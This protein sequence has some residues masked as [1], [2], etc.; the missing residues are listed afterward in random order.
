M[1]AQ[2]LDQ[3]IA[4]VQDSARNMAKHWQQETLVQIVEAQVLREQLLTLTPEQLEFRWSHLS[5]IYYSR[6]DEAFL[7]MAYRQLFG[8]PVDDDGLTTYLGM[9]TQGVPR[10]HIV[11]ILQQSPEAQRS[12]LVL[13]GTH[14]AHFIFKV[15][16]IIAR[17]PLLGKK[18]AKRLDLLI[19]AHERAEV[20]RHLPIQGYL[21]ILS[22][23]QGRIGH[24]LKTLVEQLAILQAQYHLLESKTH[25]D[26]QRKES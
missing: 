2:T 9:L 23:Y 26:D 21:D 15:R 5:H 19:Q 1:S 24:H 4:Q 14:L 6:E 16:K 8:R 12:P 20:A 18:L 25:S 3:Q 10:R 11:F 17:V 22:G 13:T 7:D